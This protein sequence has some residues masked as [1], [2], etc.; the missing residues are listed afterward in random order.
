MIKIIL[1][2]IGI[3][4]AT[5]VI[6]YFLIMRGVVHVNIVPDARTLYTGYVKIERVSLP[7]IKTNL[8]KQGCRV[9]DYKG[10]TTNRCR[11][12]ETAVP[13]EEK[14]GVIVYPRGFGWGPLSFYLTEDK[15]WATKDIP[16]SP[17]PDKF[18]EQ[19]RQDVNIIGNIVQIKERSWKITETKYPWTV[20]Y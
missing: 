8:E 5:L 18:K 10:E 15:L 16:G 2:V 12:Q 4:I 13:F 20:I 14:D 7:D 6:L 17:N 3:L 9:H 1:S 19:V 11:Y